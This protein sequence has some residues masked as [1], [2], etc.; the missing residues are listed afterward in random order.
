MIEPLYEKSLNIKSN[1]VKKILNEKLGKK[2]LEV[3][4]LIDDINT[5]ILR[6]IDVYFQLFI[7]GKRYNEYIYSDKLFFE[8]ID[9]RLIEQ[10]PYFSIDVYKYE[11]DPLNI[12]ILDILK[13]MTYSL[14]K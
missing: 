11:V 4:E 3:L 7:D 6:D 10:K 13:W 2:L 12:N 1:Y 14:F 9:I 5:D 8:S